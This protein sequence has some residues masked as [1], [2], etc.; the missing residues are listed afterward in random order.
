MRKQYLTLFFLSIILLS[1]CGC[2]A[3][4]A[5]PVIGTLYTG[6]TAPIT[7]DP[8][9][10]GQPY[11]ILGDVEGTSSATSILGII[12]TGDASVKTA[13]QNALKQIPESDDLIDVTVDYKGTSFLGLFASYT[14][15][16]KAK[17]IKHNSTSGNS[18]D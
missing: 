18:G 3:F 15:I 1:F 9:A 11:Q 2:A 14:T 6:V 4:V 8:G 5:T 16:V 10:K 7:Y 17:A 13:Y 12:A